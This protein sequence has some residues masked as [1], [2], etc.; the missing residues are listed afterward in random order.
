M[1]DDFGTVN[2][3]RSDRA[4]E[5][6]AMREQFRRHR[7]SL[8]RL[9]ADAPTER[10]ASE[11]N[12][13]IA[14]IDAAMA[15]VDELEPGMRPLVPSPRTIDSIADYEP[16][17]GS[18][19]SRVV[20][21][22]AVA[23]I[24]LA[25]IGWLIWKASSDRDKRGAIVETSTTTTTTSTAA[26]PSTVEEPPAV[27]HVLAATPTSADY[28]TIRKGTR[29]TR[30]FTIRNEGDQ[31]VTMQVARSA[32][33]CLFYEY[34]ALVPPKAKE[35]VTVTIDGARAKA[36][37]LRETI[38]VTAKADPSIATSFDVTANIQ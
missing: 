17:P 19:S 36:G 11:Y 22:A 15:K 25:A 12:R 16:R 1:S 3:S 5:I 28:G 13:L 27:V 18:S 37:Q 4:R 29:A 21:I 31:P 30:Q 26:A 23:L 9:A 20:L 35:T 2:V 14:E 24:T 32:C 8:Q 6:E 38:K 34:V 10:F 33:R 7:E